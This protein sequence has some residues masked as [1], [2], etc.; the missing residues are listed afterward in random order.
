LR[1]PLTKKRGVRKKEPLKKT[2]EREN[3]KKSTKVSKKDWIRRESGK[4]GGWAP[5]LERKEKGSWKKLR[6]KE[7]KAQ[8]GDGLLVERYWPLHKKRTLKRTGNSCGEGNSILTRS[9]WR[10]RGVK[11][12]RGGLSY[13]RNSKKAKVPPREG[14][15]MRG[16][17]RGTVKT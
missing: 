2:R 16:K 6:F 15:M 17:S 8:K 11:G 10:D 5:A 13:R 12:G 3:V 9:R 7:G 1:K 14:V 4:G